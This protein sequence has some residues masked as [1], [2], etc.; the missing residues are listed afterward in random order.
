MKKGLVL[1]LILLMVV[2]VFTG[3]TNKVAEPTNNQEKED[4]VTDVL[5][6]GGGGAGLVAAITAAEEGANV[7]LIEKLPAVG[8]NTIISAT[9]ITASDTALHEAA[10][11]PFTV[12]DHIKRTMEAG[13]DLPNLELV[14]LLAESSNDAYEWLLS[15]GLEYKL[16][17]E[18][19]W[20][21][22]PVE[23]HY[24]SQLIAAFK[25]EAAKYDNL[26]IRLENKATELIVEDNKVVGAKVESKDGEY[27]I[28][29]N[30]VVMATGGFGNAPELIGEYNPKFKNSFSVMS[31]VGPTGEGFKMAVAVGAG[32]V[33]MEYHQMRPL[34]TP[35]YWI[36]ETV[37]NEEGGG[38]LVN[39]EGVRFVNETLKPLAL[40]PEI[41]SQIDREGYI[42]FD[43]DVAATKNGTAAIDK[44]RMIEA[45][46]VE[47]LAT[48]LGLSPEAVKA[49]I[50][51]FNE[52][53][54]EFGRE[55]VGKVAVA[56]FYG[57][58]VTPAS[59]YTMAGLTFNKDAQIIDESGKPIEGLFGAGEILGGLYGSGRVAGNNTLDDIVFGKIA[60]MKAAGK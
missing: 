50:D 52:G 36:R 25:N 2:S 11:I 55:T 5:V 32:T 17:E 30:A 40:V 29:A 4:V 7:I 51:A 31:T 59:H 12:E 35:G 37:I 16:N 19:P 18:E 15:M 20:W 53:E 42:I 8:G 44:A 26:E 28:K 47:E 57:V 6:I 21:I 45:N 48:A 27:T 39:K 14:T 49:T 58:K 34:A 43:A 3:C 24:G 33:D 54:D 1:V 38:I 60:G 41:L 13:K 22:V 9:G 56:P 10:G 23:G 46:T